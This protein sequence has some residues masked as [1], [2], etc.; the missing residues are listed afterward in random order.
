MNM[1]DLQNDGVYVKDKDGSQVHIGWDGIHVE[2]AVKNEA[3]RVDNY[4]IYEKGRKYDKEWVLRYKNFPFALVIVVLYIL[5]GAVFNA[6]HPAWLLF[7]VIPLWHSF[8]EAVKKDNAN[9]FA[10]PVLATLLFL[11]AGFFFG[12][13]HPG[14]V[15]FLTIPVYYALISNLTKKED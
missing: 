7:L 8:L 15:L 6:W 9:A 5:L 13:W 10:Y 4:E 12:A 14:W 1:D 2:E 3:V 11:C